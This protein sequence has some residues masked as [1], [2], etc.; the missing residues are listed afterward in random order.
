MNLQYCYS[1]LEKGY[2]EGKCYVM[3][4]DAPYRYGYF[5][6]RIGVCL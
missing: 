3:L 1:V 6:T 4:V 2:S 5:H